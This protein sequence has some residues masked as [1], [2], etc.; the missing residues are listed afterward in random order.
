M[1]L[2]LKK[3][4]IKAVCLLCCLNITTLFATG[5]DY[6]ASPFWEQGSVSS[7]AGAL[8]FGSEN[9]NGIYGPFD[10]Q[11]QS[12]SSEPA[13]YGPGGDPIGGLPVK[14]GHAILF[15]SL[16]GYCLFKI[17]KRRKKVTIS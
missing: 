1:R 3:I 8:P 7:E 5:Y 2:K 11:E 6:S 4:G 17:G 13:L 12:L 16:A 10:S 9:Q 14:E 15:L